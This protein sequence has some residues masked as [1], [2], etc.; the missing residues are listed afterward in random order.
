[1]A[2][3]IHIANLL[4]QKFSLRIDDDQFPCRQFIPAYAHQ[5][6]SSAMVETDWS[7]PSK[8]VEGSPVYNRDGERLGTIDHMMLDRSSGRQ[9]AVLRFATSLGIG[10]RYYPVPWTKL[11]YD[12]QLGGYVADIEFSRLAKAPN[13]NK[14]SQPESPDLRHVDEYW[15]SRR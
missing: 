13:Y 12:A 14:D 8:S 1:L 6:S 7:M 15:G 11:A 3:V 2:G 10:E 9:Y 4:L 5:L